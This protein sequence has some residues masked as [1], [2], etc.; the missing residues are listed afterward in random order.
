MDL[1]GDNS[2][3]PR[4]NERSH[5]EN[6][7]RAYIAASRRSDRS[8]EARV[9][10]ARMA[11]DI[12]KRRTGK[13]FKISE[14]IVM[15]EEMYE[16][17]DEDIPRRYRNLPP[18]LVTS[19]FMDHRLGAYVTSRVAM[20]DMQPGR[21]EIDVLFDQAFPNAKAQAQRHLRSL[22]PNMYSAPVPH[23]HQATP[24][25]NYFSHGYQAQYDPPHPPHSRRSQSLAHIPAYEPDATHHPQSSTT[26]HASLDDHI[27]PVLTP[28]PGLGAHPF[29]SFTSEL[30]QNVKDMGFGY[31]EN[32]SYGFYGDKGE[33]SP[34][35]PFY[36]SN[37]ALPL[38]PVVKQED[39]PISPSDVPP[40]SPS[41]IHTPGN[42]D[43]SNFFGHDGLP[44]DEPSVQGSQIGTPGAS[45]GGE[46]WQNWLVE[47]DE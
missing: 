4:K 13:G 10:S 44:L 42:F 46:D 47:D 6:Q 19:S 9:Q 17:D 27:P 23:Q 1:P 11:S 12:H 21:T 24:V 35:L 22:Q 34:A 29:S 20:A 7:E 28:V 40:V 16:E 31:G 41:D 37:E 39:S 38:G 3:A 14:E 43:V 5:E 45:S 36:P 33:L 30:P 8:I 32:I 18:H 15:K 2:K 26:R 25:P